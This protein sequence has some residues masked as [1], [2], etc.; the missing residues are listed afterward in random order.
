MQVHEVNL[1]NTYKKTKKR[2]KNKPQRKHLN[3]YNALL[4]EVEDLGVVSIEFTS[5]CSYQK[6]NKILQQ[7]IQDVKKVQGD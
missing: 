1:K 2:I 7:I 4:A 5:L 3:N 6:R